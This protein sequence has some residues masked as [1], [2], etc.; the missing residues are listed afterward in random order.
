[1]IIYNSES[2]HWFQKVLRMGLLDLVEIILIVFVVFRKRLRQIVLREGQIVLREGQ[3]VT[4]LA[5]A[6]HSLLLIDQLN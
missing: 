2:W 4:V 5:F 1:M 6:R 3:I